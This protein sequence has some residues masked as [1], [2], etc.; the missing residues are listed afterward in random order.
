MKILIAILLI[1]ALTTSCALNPVDSSDTDIQTADTS[2]SS[3]SRIQSAIPPD[4][5]GRAYFDISVTI[6][7]SDEYLISDSA[8]YLNNHANTELMASSRGFVP[9]HGCAGTPNGGWVY[10]NDLSEFICSDGTSVR[11]NDFDFR[12][13][14]YI[15]KGSFNPEK[16]REVIPD[17]TCVSDRLWVWCESHI[18]F[19]QMHFLLPTESDSE[20]YDCFLYGFYT[21]KTAA[22]DMSIIYSLILNM[23]FEAVPKR[24]HRDDYCVVYQLDYDSLMMVPKRGEAFIISGYTS[25]QDF[26]VSGNA[27]GRLNITVF[28]EPNSYQIGVDIAAHEITDNHRD[29][30]GVVEYLQAD[31]GFISCTYDQYADGSVVAYFLYPDRTVEHRKGYDFD[32]YNEIRLLYPK[33]PQGMELYDFY[34]AVDKAVR[35]EDITS[36]YHHYTL[37]KQEC[38][39][40]YI[41]NYYLAEKRGFYTKDDYKYYLSCLL[42]SES[43]E[44]LANRRC[45]SYG[46]ELPYTITGD[47]GM[48]Y[49]L[50]PEW[51]DNLIFDMDELVIVYEDGYWKCDL[52]AM[53]RNRENE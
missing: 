15:P 25:D 49:F 7:D 53:I 40:S 51:V 28:E 24:I 33:K 50:S 44:F 31:E 41:E 10:S 13:Y 34:L 23:E 14:I 3:E 38:P 4:M 6:S 36:Y 1:L 8:A 43:V 48:L 17:F 18:D 26:K 22:E 11:R 45:K 19:T 27:D 2:A 52:M 20:V 16:Y 5:N 32:E 21:A 30:D 12:S 37:S 46:V 9:N 47:D 29:A 42:T 39:H 35:F